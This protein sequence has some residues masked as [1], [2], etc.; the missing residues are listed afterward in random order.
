MGMYIHA[1]MHIHAYIMMNACLPFMLTYVCIE[2]MH[3][4]AY[5][6]ACLIHVYV[7]VYMYV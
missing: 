3:I 4:V 1:Y 5:L 6:H 7:C 2:Y